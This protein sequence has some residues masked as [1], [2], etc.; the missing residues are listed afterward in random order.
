MCAHLCYPPHANLTGNSGGPQKKRERQRYFRRNEAGVL[1][2]EVVVRQRKMAEARKMRDEAK[3]KASGSKAT[4]K[5]RKGKAT[6]V[7][8]KE[9]ATADYNVIRQGD[10]YETAPRDEEIEDSSFLCM[11]QLYI[12]KDVYLTMKHPIR[13]MHPIKFQFLQSK[14]TFSQAASVIDRMGLVSLMER[15]CDFNISLLQQFF[16]TL[17]MKNDRAKTLKWMTGITPCEANF[18]DFAEALGYPF[19]GNTPCGRRLHTVDRPNKNKLKDLYGSGV[20][21]GNI[22]GLLPLY[23]QLVR[24]FRANI[25]P[26]GGNNDAIHTCLINLLCLAQEI[27][28]SEDLDEDFTIDVMDFIYHEMY[29]A[30]IGG[31][32]IPYAP[33]IMLLIKKTLPD[34][35]LSDDDCEDHKFKTIYEKKFVVTPSAP[36]SGSFMGD[37]RKS[38][39]RQA[40]TPS[41]A[42]QVK[43]LNWFQRNVLCMNV[44]I[45]REQYDA[46]R[47]RRHMDNTQQL[48]LHHV[49]GSTAA[50]PAEVA[51]LSYEQWNAG[52]QTPWVQMEKH[53][54]E[55]APSARAF[56]T[57][58]RAR[59]SRPAHEEDEDEKMYDA[60]ATDDDGD[61]DGGES[62]ESEES[63]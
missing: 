55:T 60:E 28:E 36:P 53:L 45:R 34:Q 13:P 1:V 27:A 35:D 46:Y 57:Y 25:A 6:R 18:Y 50:P 20:S 54:L 14:S 23:D 22:N 48:I 63:E 44:D 37:A 31:I 4:S 24:I 56:P 21:I 33:Y 47:E 2:D 12:F 26:S 61:D 58:T 3:A 52:S 49:S 43:K 16:A 5:K 9:M 59:S 10:W 32:T 17:V 7:N 19:K 11:E 42:P 51:P 38:H 39:T 40:T 8:Y 30:M 29:E 62:E 41:F 15:K